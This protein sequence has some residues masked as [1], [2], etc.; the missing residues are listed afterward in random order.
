MEVSIVRERG[1]GPIKMEVFGKIAEIII[2]IVENN[3]N[4]VLFYF[5]D[6]SEEIPYQ[7]RR[8]YSHKY[9]ND[10]FKLLFLRY[11]NL[12]SEHWSDI[13]IILQSDEPKLELYSHILLRD[14]HL[15][16]IELLRKEISDNFK[17]ITEQK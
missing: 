10:L 9:R 5:C 3:P 17:A 14:R 4:S 7:R 11:N 6:F 13:E 16:I 2:S 15:P 1:T 12:A 8:A